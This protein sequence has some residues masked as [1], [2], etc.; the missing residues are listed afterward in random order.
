MAIVLSL[1]LS[2]GL[3]ALQIYCA[4]RAYVH[5]SQGIIF[6][7]TTGLRN[8]W[9]AASV[10]LLCVIGYLC[11]LLYTVFRERRLQDVKRDFINNMTHEF[12][13]PLSSIQLCAEVLRQPGIIAHPQRLLSYAT[14]IANETAHLTG[15]VERILQM[16]KAEKRGV[17][18]QVQPFTWQGLLGAEIESYRLLAATKGGNVA[19]NMPALPVLFNGDINHLKAALSHL[20]ENAVKYCHTPPDISI[21]LH[22]GAKAVQVTVQDNGT[23]IDK[24]HQRLLFHRFYRVP[25]GNVHDVKGFGLGLNY[26]R[27]VARAHGGDVSVISQ[28]GKGSTFTLTFPRSAERIV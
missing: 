23:G 17:P 27:I 4:H 18:V 24:A 26:V 12:K 11:Y 25:S 1:L 3:I 9:F 16:E 2:L 6:R 13:T 5:N 15:Q 19:L 22:E 14:I 8:L 7:A 10:A 28:L 21:T 20:I